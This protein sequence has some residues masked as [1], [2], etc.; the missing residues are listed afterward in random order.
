M[1]APK[2][3]GPQ[4]EASFNPSED[5]ISVWKAFKLGS[6]QAL[7]DLYDRHALYLY[8]SAKDIT[9]DE[10]LLSDC[11]QD[12]FVQLWTRREK[13]ADELFSIKLYLARSL[14]RMILRKV[15]QETRLKRTRMEAHD[16]VEEYSIES[17]IVEKELETERQQSIQAAIATLNARQKE[18]L[19]L[20]FYKNL[21]Y[22]EV[23]QTMDT[24]IKGVY[25][26]INRTILS[27]RKTMKEMLIR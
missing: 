21:S 17:R 14:R 4:N 8:A 6:R 12:L 23:A 1:N 13:L 16:E 22:K 15:I 27:L 20:R 9:Q 3:S 5:E 24:D 10:A 7:N 11:I 18:V 2:P 25:N 19:Y 26:L